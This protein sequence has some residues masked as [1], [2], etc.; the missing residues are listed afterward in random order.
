MKFLPIPNTGCKSRKVPGDLNDFVVV[1]FP[2]ADMMSDQFLLVDRLRSLFQ[3]G[4]E[5][6]VS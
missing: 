5:L 1:G 6:V 3:M 4:P 2:M